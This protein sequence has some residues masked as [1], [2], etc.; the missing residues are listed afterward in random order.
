MKCVQAVMAMLGVAAFLSMATTTQAVA[1]TNYFWVGGGNVES[2]TDSANWTSAPTGGSY[3]GWNTVFVGSDRAIFPDDIG[4]VVF[5]NMPT[6]NLNGLQTG[7]RKIT[8]CSPLYV[9]RPSDNSVGGVM[10]IGSGGVEGTSIR[11]AAGT[12]G[13]A[14]CSVAGNVKADIFGAEASA[15]VLTGTPV[16]DVKT[17]YFAQSQGSGIYGFS[18]NWNF[19]NVDANKL[20]F[21][22]A[23]IS[24]PYT[25][26]WLS[27]PNFNG[28]RPTFYIV[29]C[30][31]N[32]N[33]SINVSSNRFLANVL[34]LDG[35][36]GSVNR[37]GIMRASG[38]T[39][40]VNEIHIGYGNGNTLRTWVG[41]TN[42]AI[43]IRGTGTVALAAWDNRSTNNTL[44]NVNTGTTTTFDPTGVA[45]QYVDTGSRD[46][47][48]VSLNPVDWQNNF[49]FD[50]VVLGAGD[51]IKLVGDAN[52]EGGGTNA[53]YAT[54]MTGLGGGATVKLNGHNVYLLKRPSNVTFDTTGGGRVYGPT[55]GTLINIR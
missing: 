6:V 31:D 3:P 37:Y 21:R 1:I 26:T 52:I 18:T 8:F 7:N 11:A 2:W 44:F 29:N 34:Q 33:G 40:G 51:T 49:A 17:F 4:P 48:S 38:G 28:G 35:W 41:L 12:Y 53:L 32:A 30:G 54:R 27:E 46:R 47:S 20:T 42:T 25:L 39:V 23:S 5:T 9:D 45:T 14:S 16:F 15:P 19:I 13:V 50:Q 36:S 43:Y 10:S 55:S 24:G 22:S